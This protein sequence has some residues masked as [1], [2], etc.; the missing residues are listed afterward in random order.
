ML[1]STRGIVLHYT[2]YAESS[3]ISHI[4]TEEFGKQSYIIN[5]VRSKKNKGKSIFLQPLTLVDLEVYHSN[6]KSIHRI[7]DFKVN[8]PFFKIPFEPIRRSLAFFMAEVLYKCLTEEHKPQDNLFDFLHHSIAL[9]DADLL[10]VENYHLFFM[11]KFSGPL[12]FY[13]N[14]NDRNL[15]KYFD[16]KS[17]NFSSIEP[18]HGDY[19]N[20]W[21][22]DLL[23]K[24]HEVSVE[25]LDTILLK[26]TERA[27]FLEGLLDYYRLHFQGLHELK[28]LSILKQLFA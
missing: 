8:T 11:L 18:S 19:L 1:Q 25:H 16:L 7:K 20:V 22:T 6:K 2:R 5:S 28:S 15:G 21:Q 9:L 13:P 4:Y 14:F 3:I 27:E 24:L 10:G 12:G 23:Q 17:G 26:G